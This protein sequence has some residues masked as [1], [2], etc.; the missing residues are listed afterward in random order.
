MVACLALCRG[1]EAFQGADRLPSGDYGR[2]T[3][4]SLGASYR[5]L[6]N[7]DNIVVSHDPMY[8]APGALWSPVL[9]TRSIWPVRRRFRTTVWTVRRFGSS[10]APVVRQGFAVRGQSYVT[11]LPPPWMP[12]AT[13]P[14]W[15]RWSRPGCGGKPKWASGI[16]PPRRSPASIPIV[17]V[18]WPKPSKHANP[19]YALY[20]GMSRIHIHSTPTIQSGRVRPVKPD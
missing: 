20:S 5:P 13:R 2:R 12:T 10:A 15:R 17:S 6:P 1:Y 18:S 7:R 14:I 4:E 11:D 9:T 3:W 16:R 8:R 19:A